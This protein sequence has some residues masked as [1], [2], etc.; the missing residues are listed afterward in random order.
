LIQNETRRQKRQ[1]SGIDQ[2]EGR[3]KR[4]RML[5][6]EP[7]DG[8]PEH[9]PETN[10]YASA[11]KALLRDEKRHCKRQCTWNDHHEGRVKRS[12]TISHEP[13]DSG[14]HSSRDLEP[15]DFANLAIYVNDGEAIHRFWPVPDSFGPDIGKCWY[16]D[17]IKGLSQFE[18]DFDT[19]HFP[20][21]QF[22]V[23]FDTGHLPYIYKDYAE[24]P[25]TIPKRHQNGGRIIDE[26][27][28]YV[29]DGPREY[30][31]WRFP[32]SLNGLHCPSCPKRFL[33][34]EEVHSRFEVVRDL[35]HFSF[36]LE[37]ASSSQVAS[38]DPKDKVVDLC[39]SM[40]SYTDDSD[41]SDGDQKKDTHAP[42]NECIEPDSEQFVWNRPNNNDMSSVSSDSIEEMYSDYN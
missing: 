9:H 23:D 12:R 29:H 6:H 21:S 36:D 20:L 33:F 17:V 32:E 10:G 25:Y 22:E 18:V 28:I 31:Y 42:F 37:V 1:N 41:D 7:N 4:S 38:I 24:M 40:V 14:Q 39:P 26:L 13:N 16:L 5:S 35:P 15:N 27:V 2:R 11:V 3:I 8:P 34:I 30:K 19:G